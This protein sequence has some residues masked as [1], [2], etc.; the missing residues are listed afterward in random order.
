MQC[1]ATW[2]VKFVVVT[3][4]PEAEWVQVY[5]EALN[6]RV[7][8]HITTETHWNSIVKNNFEFADEL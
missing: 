7:D 1:I 2:D 4:I 8:H 3:I 5:R 6:T